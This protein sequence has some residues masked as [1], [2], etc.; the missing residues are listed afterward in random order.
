MNSQSAEPVDALKTYVSVLGK[1]VSEQAKMI[2]D[3][4]PRVSAHQAY[5]E[6]LFESRQ[7]S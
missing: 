6:P 7:L 5:I 3:I 4:K 2:N 1:L